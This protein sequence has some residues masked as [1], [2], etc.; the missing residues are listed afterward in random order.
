MQCAN[1]GR[2]TRA[3]NQHLESV[4]QAYMNELRD[5][6]E[7]VSALL[8]IVSRSSQ[9]RRAL[10]ADIHRFIEQGAPGHNAQSPSQPAMNAPERTDALMNELERAI[11]SMQQRQP[12]GR[13]HGTH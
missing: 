12:V 13:L 10:L 3:M 4:L 5:E 2:G 9:E 7:T 11:G 8:N 1:G 6:A